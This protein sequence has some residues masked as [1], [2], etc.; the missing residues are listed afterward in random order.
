[1]HKRKVT[2]EGRVNIPAE[3][4][5][6]FRIKEDDW[7]EVTSNRTSIII[8]K[9]NDPQ[10]CAVTGKVSKNLMKFGETYISKEGLEI[11]KKETSEVT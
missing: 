11:I 2:K 6:M 7:V 9:F 4:L 10:I 3:L 5:A 8:K 1:M